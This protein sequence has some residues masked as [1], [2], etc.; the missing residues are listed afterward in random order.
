MNEAMIPDCD[1]SEVVDIAES[2]QNKF[3][4]FENGN[5]WGWGY[6][7][8]GVLGT[9]DTTSVKIPTL[10]ATG[11]SEMYPT[12][13]G[14]YNNDY[15]MLYIKKTDGTWWGTGANLYGRMGDGTSSTISTFTEL[16][17]PTGHTEITRLWNNG[18]SCGVTFIEV[19]DGTIYG[20]GY[21]GFGQIG[22]GT[23]TD[24]SYWTEVIFPETI[25]I[26]DIQG[27]YGYYS[28]GAST[29]SFT[30][31]LS[32]DG[33][34][35]TCGDNGYGQLGDGTTTDSST[36][37]KV[38]DN[39]VDSIL[40]VGGGLGST[41]CKYTS[42][43]KLTVWGYNSQGQLGIGSTTDTKTPTEISISYDE[44]FGNTSGNLYSF[45]SQIFL[46]IG[47]EI[48]ATG[49]NG[50]GNLGTGDS[51]NCTSFTKT[52]IAGNIT[53]IQSKGYNSGGRYNLTLHE[54][55]SLFGIGYGGRDNIEGI[56]EVTAPD[57]NSV[58]RRMF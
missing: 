25:T 6:N 51:T 33:A 2:G 20:C 38:L 46:K 43:D 55:G 5:L 22:D 31:F 18:F 27:G 26:K 17:I 14:S 11:V 53:D 39:G 23:T 19:E 1:S 34:V 24:R 28:S 56:F 47:S 50:A 41:Y 30:T 49:H 7:A 54:N 12:N 8:R 44:I 40:V 15:G 3:I 48:W 36:V 4:L 58:P 21:N 29:V 45:Y 37:I 57:T 42:K 16:T 52:A 35:Y 9:G 10:L 13:F 32:T